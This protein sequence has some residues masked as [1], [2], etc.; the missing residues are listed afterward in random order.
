MDRSDVNRLPDW[1]RKEKINLRD[2]HRMKKTLREQHLHT[3]CESARCPNRGTCFQK[4]TATFLLLGNMCTRNCGFCSVESG[5]PGPPDP[6]EP[7][8]ISKTIRDLGIRYAV[9][10]MVTGDDL[11]DGGAAHIVSTVE[12]IRRINDVRIEVLTS[13]FNGN[14][15][16]LDNVLASSINVF[17]HNVEMAPSLYGKIRPEG[18]YSQSLSVLKRAADTTT[19][20]V[21]SGFMVGLGETREELEQL[22]KDLMDH[23]VTILTIG[24]YLRPT[25]ANVPVQHYYAPEEFQELEQM[26]REMGFSR[27]FAG[28]FVRSS[29]MADE[30]FQALN[31]V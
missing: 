28:P 17:N 11:A 20:P 27:V 6:H 14:L 3:V 30:L 21:K 1:I 5:R 18:R 8:R 9:L 19:I 25:A 10:T 24:Q 31:H 4:G 12:A 16:A 7:E 22:M 13:D 23:G 26:A 29:Y 15:Q 2:L